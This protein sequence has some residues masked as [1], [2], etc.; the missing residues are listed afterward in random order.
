M[1]LPPP[2][3]IDS[4]E[5]LDALIESLRG[6]T[7]LAVDTESNSLYAYRERVCLIQLSTRTADY[8]ID[9]LSIDTLEPLEPLF[10][11]ASV[12][13]VFHA[14]EYD[15]MCMKRDFGFSF[16]NL[17]DTMIAARVCGRK[18]IGLGSLLDEVVGVAVDKS[19]Q[20]DDWGMR[21]LPPDSLTY[22][23]IDTHYLPLLHDHFVQEL[24]EL[25][26]LEE[27]REAF[28]DVCRVP[29]ARR[30]PFDAT[31]FWRMSLPN[32][33]TRREAA[34]LREVYAL[35]ERIA[36]ERD[37]PPF[38]IFPDRTLVAVAQRAPTRLN[39]LRAIE[40]MS[41]GQIRR[42]GQT[43]I[44][45]V[46]VGQHADLPTPPT[47]EPPS[48][49]VVVERYSA[50]REWRKTRAQERGVESDVIISKDALWTLAV[51]APSS[52]D[53]MDNVPGLGPWRRAVYGAEILAVI[54]RHRR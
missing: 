28:R 15:L 19:H 32:N 40:G 41:P 46:V 6:E 8:L 10:A 44:D 20:R 9:P 36:Q 38:K 42:Y 37:V 48:D 26:R 30:E 47:P 5:A 50:L 3:Y 25:E 2:T 24:V 4:N 39:D 53:E 7:L 34:I 54:R 43:L 11:D 17:F 49:P 13:K 52:L 31:G 21:P 29:A 33:L 12:E 27:A 16:E 35:R 14:A 22:A 1:T 45:A 51:R 23:Q 18:L